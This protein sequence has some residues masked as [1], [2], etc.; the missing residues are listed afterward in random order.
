MFAAF[1]AFQ[2]SV[3]RNETKSS[4]VYLIHK[5]GNY[6]AETRIMPTFKKKLCGGEIVHA[7][8]LTGTD[9]VNLH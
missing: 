3:Y 5:N 9:I 1:C 6:W 2:A 8:K 7:S 4:E